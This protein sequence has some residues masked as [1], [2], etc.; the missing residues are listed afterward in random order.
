VTAAG[1][2]P[3][4][5]RRLEGLERQQRR[6]K[7]WG[8]GLAVLLLTALAGVG[9]TLHR[10]PPS[11]G[12]VAAR[13]LTLH[14]PVIGAGRAWLGPR[15]GGLRLDLLDREGK[16]RTTLGLDRNG[17]PSLKL[18]DRGYKLRAELAL[19]PQGDPGLNLVDQA[20]LLR[21]AL[22]SIGPGYQEAAANLERPLSSLVLFNQDGA[23]VW[24]APLNWRR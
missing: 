2:G 16:V 13:T 11:G 24:R 14:D 9:V 18:Y 3:D 7:V 17:D 5:S 19:N 22:G 8:A 23:P 10:A 4:L 6:L 21:V 1:A 20:G 15:D 12:E